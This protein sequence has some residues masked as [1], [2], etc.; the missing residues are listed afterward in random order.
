MRSRVIKGAKCAC[1]QANHPMDVP[2]TH[3]SEG[4]GLNTL[5]V[6]DAVR[7][8]QYLMRVRVLAQ[9]GPPLSL[10][11]QAAVIRSLSVYYCSGV[12]C[13]LPAKPVDS[14]EVCCAA[15]PSAGSYLK[16]SGQQ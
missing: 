2:W 16:H 5:E 15:D 1:L 7:E 13:V 14:M 12:K 9:H 6:A 10:G 3:P 4:L 11:L 8:Y